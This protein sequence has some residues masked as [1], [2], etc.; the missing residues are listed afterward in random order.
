M[1]NLA[2]LSL[3]VILLTSCGRKDM[4]I[5]R[6]NDLLVIDE[7]KF[8]KSKNSYEYHVTDDFEVGWYYYSKDKFNV[9][10]TLIIIKK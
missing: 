9:N 1:R 10:D 8:I 5:N 4:V 3:L 7:V 2:L 6:K